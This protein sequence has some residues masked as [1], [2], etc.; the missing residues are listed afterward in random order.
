[1]RK[2]KLKFSILVII[3][4][5]LAVISFW[6]NTLILIG[7]L[8]FLGFGKH[9]TIPIKYE[10]QWFI[11]SAVVGTGAESLVMLSGPWFYQITNLFNFP[12]WLPFLWGLAGVTG[13]SLYQ[14]IKLPRAYARGFLRSGTNKT[15]SN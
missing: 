3:L 10:V 6:E 13:I 7:C 11:I 5:I 2:R 4:T 8:C 9:Q 12:L 15:N 1:M 14:S